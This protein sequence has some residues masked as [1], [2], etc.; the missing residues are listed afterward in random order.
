MKD[1]KKCVL[2]EGNNNK[3]IISFDCGRV[4]FIPLVKVRIF[5]NAYWLAFAKSLSRPERHYEQNKLSDV[6]KCILLIRKHALRIATLLQWLPES[7]A[8]NIKEHAIS[9]GCL[10]FLSTI[11]FCWRVWRHVGWCKYHLEDKNE[12][13]DVE[14]YS[15]ALSFRIL[16]IFPNW[17]LISLMKGINMD[18]CS[19]FLLLHKQTYFLNW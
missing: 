14:K 7:L 5:Q 1:K 6:E 10:F 4:T 19:Y 17:F 16:I 18:K 12:E 15:V 9:I 13:N 2:K 8:F 3:H 11:S